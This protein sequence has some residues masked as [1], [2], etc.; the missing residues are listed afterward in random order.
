MHRPWVQITN[1]K[2]V[3]KL[4]WLHLLA[5]SKHWK[6]L[7]HSKRYFPD[8]IWKRDFRLQQKAYSKHLGSCTAELEFELPSWVQ[9]KAT[10]DCLVGGDWL[11]LFLYLFTYMQISGGKE[12]HL[13][14]GARRWLTQKP[15]LIA[16]LE[17]AMDSNSAAE[18]KLYLS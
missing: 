2:S 15:P 5:N 16:S 11:G 3:H 12:S 4:R 17:V 8:M 1:V 7:I 14:Q 6:P 9:A 18:L 13:W 10:S